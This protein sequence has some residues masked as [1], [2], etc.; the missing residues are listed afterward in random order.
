MR[1]CLVYKFAI[2]ALGFGAM[3]CGGTE[4]PA[5]DG[6]QDATLGIDAHAEED[7]GGGDDAQVEVDAFVPPDAPDVDGGGSDDGGAIDDGGAFVD[8]ARVC[9]IGQVCSDSQPC[10]DGAGF[11]C[12]GFGDNGFCAPFAPECGGFVSTPCTGGRTCIRGGGGDLG[13]CATAE[14]VECI[15]TSVV[16]NGISSDGCPDRFF[17]DAGGGR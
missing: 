15:C 5:G 10:P 6:G 17:P 8:A 14:E 2:V 4:A 9:M 7:A 1:N 11:R 3:A 12:Y 13:Y 16:E